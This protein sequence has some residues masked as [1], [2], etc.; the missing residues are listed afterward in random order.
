MAGLRNTSRDSCDFALESERIWRDRELLY[1]RRPQLQAT[2][3]S[4]RFPA[5]KLGGSDP[6]SRQVFGQLVASPDGQAG[7]RPSA[8]EVKEKREF[9]ISQL[10]PIV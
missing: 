9:E 7:T 1:R 3:G 5:R 6:R 2:Q 10:W 8:A 4:G